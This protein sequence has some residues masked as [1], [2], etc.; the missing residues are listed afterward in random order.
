[1]R[2]RAI[3]AG[4]IGLALAAKLPSAFALEG[5]PAV[6]MAVLDV[7]RVRRT[8]AAVLSVRAQLDVYL[9]SYRNDTLKE[10][11][12]LRAAQ[13]GLAAKRSSL[14][15]E[16]YADERKKLEERLLDAQGRVQ[17]RRD[18]L[19][20]VNA[21]ALEQVKSTLEAI[22]TEI[23]GERQLGLIL[24]KDLVVFT[25]PGME[26]TEDVLRRL[27]QRLPT[28]KIADPGG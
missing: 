19:E 6:R 21:E 16:A 3:I 17:R 20:R 14:S 12:A 8:A 22:V 4:G 1:M 26:I 10:E 2:R 18:A 13:D 23:A 5:A 9:D 11:Q 28:V 27:D 7:E 24:R 25:A 15:A